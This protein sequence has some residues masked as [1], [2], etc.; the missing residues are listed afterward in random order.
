MISNSSSKPLRF[1][2]TFR[3]S[4]IRLS[5]CECVLLFST[6]ETISDVVNNVT[7]E[8]GSVIEDILSFS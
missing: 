5:G 8:L 2:N 7:E 6:A 4:G 3:G 1:P